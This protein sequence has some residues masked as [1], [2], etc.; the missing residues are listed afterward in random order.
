MLEAGFKSFQHTRY[1]I[2]VDEIEGDFPDEILWV[3][4][5]HALE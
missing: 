2:G 4:S 1:V 3:V 5:E